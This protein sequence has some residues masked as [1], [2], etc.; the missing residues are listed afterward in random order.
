MTA[1]T[2][3]D[4]LADA[5]GFGSRGYT[6][7]DTAGTETH[8]PFGAMALEAKAVGR[9]LL[10]P[11]LRGGLRRGDRVA[12]LVSRPR[13]FVPLF[14]GAIDAGLVPVPI[15]TDLRGSDGARARFVAGIV[16]TSGARLAIADEQAPVPVGLS[17]V[18]PGELAVGS[19]AFACVASASSAALSAPA[20]SGEP[21]GPDD[22]AFLQFTSG[23]TAA[24]KGVVVTHGSLLA[25]ARAIAEHG[26]AV[27]AER[28]VGVSWLPLHHDMGLIGFVVTPMVC[29]V[30]V[31]LIPTSRF[32]RHPETW[33]DAVHRHRG[34][35]TFAP[36]F[37]LALARR[38]PRP[39]WD[40]SCLRVL[41]CGAEPLR[42][43]VL[44][45]FL[46]TYRGAGLPE[47]ALTPC[48]GLAEAT[49]AVT[50][51]SLGTPLRV[52]RV[53]PQALGRRGFADP[54]S[55]EGALEI[56]GC[57]RA[58]PGHEIAIVDDRGA[59]LPARREGHVMVRGPSVTP[60]YFA[61][62]GS[63]TEAFRDGWLATG[64][65][66]YVADDDLFVCGRAKEILIVH[67]RNLHPEPIEQ[68]AAGAPGVREGRVVAFTR[69]G[70]SGEEV[71]VCAEAAGSRDASL[72][73][74][75]GSRI[76]DELGLPVADVVLLPPGALPRGSS[77]KLQRRAARS[78]Y[79]A[80]TLGAGTPAA[81]TPGAG[82]PAAGTPRGGPLRDGD[83]PLE[84]EP[85][86][87]EEACPPPVTSRSPTT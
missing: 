18:T 68:A 79:L 25:N 87:G 34:T 28:D 71:V 78:A 37:A 60:G 48:Y 53:D 51:H 62:A 46:S 56:V 11:G 10:G 19:E 72:A 21:P 75:V 58:L 40:L 66:G 6:F 73:R 67:G 38:R 64:D 63:T 35:I 20:A 23:S 52:D 17:R 22:V 36:T 80:G 24:P 26:L 39:G 43:G 15:A 83:A 85:L 2:L 59:P 69:P 70:E 55:E 7:A 16:R 42:A 29:G 44:R 41:G 82:T 54:T 76:A 4:C 45:D 77:G 8:V 12:L 31:V 81:G 30:P 13:D 14:F 86:E 74:A 9:R 27:D 49:L 61:D 3:A 47:T 33:L 50:F 84:R 5:A 1:R 65:L 57:G 32:V